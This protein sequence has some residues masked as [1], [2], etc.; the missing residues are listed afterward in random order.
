MSELKLGQIIT[1][2]QQ[3]DAIHVAVVPIIAADFLEPG[4]HVGRVDGERFGLCKDSLGVVDPFLRNTIA[5]GQKCWLFLYPNTVTGMRH[6]W[7]HPAFPG[8]M[9]TS[10]KDRSVSEQWIR[11]FAEKIGQTYDG[12]MD[13]AQWWHEE[14][15]YTNCG[16]NEGYK[17]GSESEWREFWMHWQ[18]V[19]GVVPSD[20]S[21]WFFSCSC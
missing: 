9:P 1:D 21:G 4:D 12:L 2:E 8:S 5:P 16:Q 18:Q 11:D 13:A 17:D 7:E 6:H 15:E 20:T 3:R 14:R 19:T 10:G